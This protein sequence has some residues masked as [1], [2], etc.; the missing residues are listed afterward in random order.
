[1]AITLRSSDKLI[2]IETGHEWKVER[3][4]RGKDGV[5]KDPF[6]PV[7]TWI[8]ILVNAQGHKQF[9]PEE[10]IWTLFQTPPPKEA[11]PQAAVEAN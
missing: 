7:Q 11:A 5:G 10:R 9:V 1:M 6:K 4:T 8:Y 2:E 3:R